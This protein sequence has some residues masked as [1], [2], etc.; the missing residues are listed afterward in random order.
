M[1]RS[2]PP[3]VICLP[4]PGY[5]TEEATDALHPVSVRQS[6][7]GPLD[8]PV[9]WLTGR[10]ISFGKEIAH[11]PIIDLLKQNFGMEEG[12][13]EAVIRGKIEQ[14]MAALGEELRPEI[15]Y[16]K[17]LLSV[18]PGDEAVLN[19]D[20]QQR[21][22][23][24]FETIR[25]MTLRG[26]ERRP[27]ILVVEDLHWIDATSEEL[28]RYLTDSIAGARVLLLLT[29]RPGYHNPFGER[30]YFSRLVLQTLS[31]PESTRLAEGMLATS[32]LPAELQELIF[33]KAE[34]NPFFV[35]EVLKS[36]LEV[37]GLQRQ[38][39]R[40]R[41]AKP[42]AD[43]YVPETIQ[44]V[45]M[46]R[47]D[48]LEESPKKALQLASV[49]GREFTVRLLDRISDLQAQLDRFLQELKVL[50]F[51]Y[52]RS[53][54]P[55]LAYMFKH[56]LT[57][58]VAYNS[59]LVQRRK[60]LH[61]VVA[62]AVE[63][64]YAG[65]LAE[66][67]EMLAYHYERAEVWDKALEYLVK[68]GQKAQQAYAN[69]EALALYDRALEVC[70]R[71][72]ATVEPA[73]LLTIYSGKGAVHFLRSEFL[74][75]VGAYQRTLE[76]AQQLGDRATAAEVLYQI[77]VDF[78]WAHEFERALDYAERAKTL[79]LAIDSKSSL[80]GS[81]WLIGKVHF[82]TSQLGEGA[83]RFAE[84]LR[85]SREAGD[86]FLE[87]YMLFELGLLDNW[88]GEY[89]RSRELQDQGIAIGRTHNLAYILCWTVWARGLACCGRGEYEQA[90][91]S[92]QEGL[93][94]SAQLGDRAAKPRILNSLGWLHGELYNLETALRYNREAAE[95]AYAIGEPELVAYAEINLAVDYLMLGDLVQAGR[96]LEKVQRAAERPGKW[97]DEWMK[98]RYSQ[99]LFHSLGELWLK[100][101]DTER[102][103]MFAD[104][105]LRLAEP[106]ST[107]KNVVKGRRLQ[108]QAFLAL[109][110]L[111]EAE[112]AL[113]KALTVALEIGNPPQLWKT[114]AALGELYERQGESDRMRSAYASALQG[115]EGVAERLNNQELKQ[116]F[117][118]AHP[119][120]AIRARLSRSDK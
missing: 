71:L 41:L 110:R 113:R 77:G 104:E 109:G 79:A 107:R 4:A 82:M 52:E 66:S 7:A 91:A 73:T 8:G 2:L 86:K 54:Y 24:L 69:Q 100:K 62:T 48:R 50:E 116:T 120:Q 32:E 20:V 92:L 39:G 117:L 114:Y 5:S 1:T 53:F 81:L 105:C 19:M 72:G 58:D 23:K 96:Y 84:G 30:T 83:H 40:Y 118:S 89:E 25:A 49:I 12:D 6:Y 112:E 60:A 88:Q 93:R 29:Y 14:G 102:A 33:R 78:L 108:G 51:I 47:I 42:L 74:P 99:Y 90:M 65:R 98:W 28:L 80:A 68:A 87:G 101:G 55:E 10:C 95:A 45:I 31:E 43:L 37:G 3:G 21:R 111:Q 57:H 70:E 67:Y 9:T 18:D 106:T 75:S 103:L 119:V 35:E 59:L 76:L 97:G 64:L 38:N 11:L 27:L 34:G 26:A 13:D 44:D 17:Y 85:I 115:I 15:P 16:I 36:L 94:L 56:A 63:E 61:R 22:V 46:A